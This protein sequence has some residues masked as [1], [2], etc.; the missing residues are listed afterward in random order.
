M[1]PRYLS[2][3][4]GRKYK[5]VAKPKEF[6]PEEFP[7]IGLSGLCKWTSSFDKVCL[8]LAGVETMIPAN[9]VQEDN[10]EADEIDDSILITTMLEN[11]EGVLKLLRGLWRMTKHIKIRNLMERGELPEFDD[12]M[13]GKKTKEE[14][15]NNWN[16][17]L[18]S[19]GALASDLK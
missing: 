19:T 7:Y 2:I 13:I 6:K 16:D 17:Y 5:V 3:I 4:A 9:C 10:G 14:Y 18:S 12:T 8:E 11:P 1:A 15:D